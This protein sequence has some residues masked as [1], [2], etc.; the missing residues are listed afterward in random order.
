MPDGGQSLRLRGPGAPACPP[1]TPC[2][3]RRL[4]LSWVRQR[5]RR[6]DHYELRVLSGLSGP[7]IGESDRTLG[8]RPLQGVTNR[9][10]SAPTFPGGLGPQLERLAGIG[11]PFTAQAGDSLVYWRW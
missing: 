1:A 5:Q 9:Y 3:R 10:H 8:H 6:I 2:G 4:H 7:S 11:E